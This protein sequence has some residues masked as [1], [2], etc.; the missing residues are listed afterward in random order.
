MGFQDRDY[1][2]DRNFDYTR[3]RWEEEPVIVPRGPRG[4]G[5]P[6]SGGS[7][8]PWLAFGI[9]VVVG[10][11]LFTGGF[12]KLVRAQ[13]GCGQ[14]PWDQDGA[15]VE[16][17]NQRLEEIDARLGHWRIEL[18]NLRVR[19]DRVSSNES[20]YGL[21]VL[22]NEKR[23]QYNELLHEARGMRVVHGLVVDNLHR[24]TAR[25]NACVAGQ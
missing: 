25:F 17:V 21:V 23:D 5:P 11:F 12:G 14:H 16:A 19:I 9:A 3:G 22:H 4:G 2:R 8:G 18:E 7:W 10:L 6:E 20:R 24:K 13:W 1:V 15:V